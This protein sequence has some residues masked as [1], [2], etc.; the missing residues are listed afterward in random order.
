MGMAEPEKQAYSASQLEN[1]GCGNVSTIRRRYFPEQGGMLIE[2]QFIYTVVKNKPTR[3]I[4]YQLLTLKDQAKVDAWEH[5]QDLISIR[6]IADC[7]T[8]SLPEYKDIPAPSRAYHT[9]AERAGAETARKL[10]EAEAKAI[11]DRRQRKNELMAMYQGLP[12]PA[13]KAAEAK[14]QILTACKAF[15]NEGKYKGRTKKGRKTWSTKGLND[16]C[17]AFIEGTLELPAEI[18]NIFTRKG[19]RSLVPAS[20]LNWRNLYEEQNLYG[21]ADHYV[22]KAGATVLTIIQ[23][24]FVIAMIHDYPHIEPAAMLKA[25]KARFRGETLPSRHTVGRFMKHWKDTHISLYLYITNPDE[26]R[27]RH[28]FAFGDAS[29]KVIRLNQRWE[30][31]STKA[32]ILCFDGRCCVIGTIDVWSRRFKLLV[33]PTS[34]AA[35]IA[36][37]FRR[38]LIGWGVPKEFR[39]DCGS[40]YTSFHVERVC[41][42]LDTHHHL[43]NEFHPEEKPHIERAFKTFSHGIVE[44]LPG[45][46]GHSVADRKAIES[47]KSFANRLMTKGE[48]VEVKLTMAEFQSICDSWTENI[49]NQDSHGGLGGMSP[50]EKARSWNEPIVRINNERALDVLLSPAPSNDGMRTIGKKG[51]DVTFNGIKLQYKAGEFSGHE[52]ESCRVLI[53]ESDLG[54]APIFLTNGEFLCLAEDPKWYGISNQ[55]VAIHAKAQQKRVLSEQKKEVKRIAKQADTRNIAAEIL[56]SREEQASKVVELPKQAKEYSTPALEQAA[57]AVAERDRKTEMP[58]GTPITEEMKRGAEALL[59]SGK[60]IQRQVQPELQKFFDL[61]KKVKAGIASDE[62]RHFVDA[63]HHKYNRTAVNQ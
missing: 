32:D 39:T 4:P 58:C 34:K 1:I 55:E 61:D 12:E 40:D 57:I 46:V 6:E 21:L 44:L 42:A 14:H 5:Q 29:E 3:H 41:D 11:E 20:I 31:D 25:L 43:C 37:L 23:Q 19:K 54:R 62:E 22:S 49:Y 7:A 10:K 8:T 45:F 15:L 18:V 26:W 9:P 13:K 16:F 48:T 17:Q 27:S 24:N 53:D 33:S 60:K 30:A 51:I 63:F 59:N 36:A 52:G 38:C 56:K 28:M 35:A 50:A 47:R 2:E